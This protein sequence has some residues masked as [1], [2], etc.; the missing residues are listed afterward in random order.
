M[1]IFVTGGRWGDVWEENPCDLHVT[2]LARRVRLRVDLSILSPRLLIDLRGSAS[3]P[4]YTSVFE[5]SSEP[6]CRAYN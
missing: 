3:R 2:R 5:V 4:R 1:N 6:G